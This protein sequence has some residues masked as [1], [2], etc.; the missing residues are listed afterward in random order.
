MPLVAIWAN[1][2]LI[3]KVVLGCIIVI[4]ISLIDVSIYNTVELCLGLIHLFE[5]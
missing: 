2:N 3:A 4:D 5:I 1:V